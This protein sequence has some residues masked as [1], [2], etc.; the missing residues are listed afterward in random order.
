MDSSKLGGGKNIENQKITGS[1]KGRKYG[2]VM[3]SWLAG[4]NSIVPENRRGSPSREQTIRMYPRNTK[5]LQLETKHEDSHCTKGAVRPTHACDGP[6]RQGNPST[7]HRSRRA[8]PPWRGAGTGNSPRTAQRRGGTRRTPAKNCTAQTIKPIK[9]A[10][11]QKPKRFH[12]PP[13]C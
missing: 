12:G 11:K 10:Q 8:P 6:V 2:L 13:P 9:T 1:T 4:G 7:A 3:R 5:N